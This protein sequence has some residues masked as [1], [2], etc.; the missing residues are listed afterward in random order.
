MKNI[1]LISSIILLTAC[2]TN[3]NQPRTYTLTSSNG[4]PISTHKSVN[5]CQAAALRANIRKTNDRNSQ[6]NHGS[7]QRTSVKD[8]SLQKVSCK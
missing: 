4:T 3:S 7:H 8:G 6:K 5:E 1:I 2:S